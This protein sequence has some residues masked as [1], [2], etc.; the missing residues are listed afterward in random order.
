MKT[1]GKLFKGSQ[2]KISSS[3]LKL[4][5]SNANSANEI[6]TPAT[7]TST[8]TKLS[9]SLFSKL[10]LKKLKSEKS[11]PEAPP[12]PSS[13][14]TGSIASFNNNAQSIVPEAS[15]DNRATLSRGH[16]V[17][18]SKSNL[19]KVSKTSE[20]DAQNMKEVFKKL[21]TYDCI[22]KVTRMCS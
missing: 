22:I 17:V 16:S 15:G 9:S 3:N 13:Q 14:S 7:D 18:S 20:R 6:A 21:V 8:P 10:S 5:G 11:T 4:A 19:S 1:L 2:Q 12:V